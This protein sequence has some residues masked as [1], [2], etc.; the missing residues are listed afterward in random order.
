M[1]IKV[2]FIKALAEWI[3]P[4]MVATLEM[5]HATLRERGCRRFEV[6]RDESEPTEFI[7]YQLFNS[8]A[9][10]ELHSQMEHYQNWQS[11]TATMLAEPA[12]MSSYT[13]LF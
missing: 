9:D 12:R 11:V 4:F 2:V 3:E 10:A 6:L 7:L 1:L 13:Q 5:A 8:R